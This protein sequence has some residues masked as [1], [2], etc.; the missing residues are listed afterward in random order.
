MKSFVDYLDCGRLERIKSRPDIVEFIVSKID[1]I[2]QKNNSIKKK[3][4]I[5]GMKA[6][7]FADWCLVT[8]MIKDK[9]HL[10]PEGLEQI[11]KIKAIMNT[12]RKFKKK[13]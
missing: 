10:T 1:D 6:L 7:D 5:L 12:G 3:N 8:D 11:R 13:T 2:S 9:K 4:P